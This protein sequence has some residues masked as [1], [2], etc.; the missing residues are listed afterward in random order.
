MA[1]AAWSACQEETLFSSDDGLDLNILSQRKPRPY[2]WA[3]Q[4]DP[5]LLKE[6]NRVL[7]IGHRALGRDSRGS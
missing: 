7:L 1:P 4:E 3:F 5:E 2:A 6:G